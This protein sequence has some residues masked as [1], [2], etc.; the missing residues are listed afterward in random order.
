VTFLGLEIDCVKLEVRVDAAKL[1]ALRALLAGWG[2]RSS[3]TGREIRSLVGSLASVARAVRPARLFLRRAI[4]EFSSRPLDVEAP[5]SASFAADLAWWTAFMEVFNGVTFVP[6]PVPCR[7]VDLRLFTDASPSG[8]G[9][10]FGSAWFAAPVPR[11]L[12][13]LHI[14]ILELYALVLAVSTWRDRLHASTLVV[15]SDNM[16]VVDSVNA[17]HARDPHM[18][19]LLRSLHFISACSHFS[20]RVRY[21]PSAF[22][23]SADALSRV[24]VDPAQWVR[25]FRLT[26]AAD[27]SSTVPRLFPIRY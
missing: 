6:D 24:Q 4:E 25:F 22:N 19:A 26:P 3:A 9:A 15:R 1:A 18:A 11:C 2:L 7:D 16:A 5:L 23:A 8:V 12:M 27:R 13:G 10:V 14:G 17:L 20:V 21:I